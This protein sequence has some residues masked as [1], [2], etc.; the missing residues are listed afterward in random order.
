M[1]GTRSLQLVKEES[2]SMYIAAERFNI[3]SLDI[4]A[5]K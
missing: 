3:W 2:Y 4:F 1:V 5:E